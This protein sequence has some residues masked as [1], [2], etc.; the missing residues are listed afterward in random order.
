MKTTVL[1]LALAA[2]ASLSVAPAFAQAG[3]CPKGKSYDSNMK[4]CVAEKRG[5]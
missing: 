1:A 5:S 2:A 3:S 4:K